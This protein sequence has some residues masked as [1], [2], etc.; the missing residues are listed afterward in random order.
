MGTEGLATVLRIGRLTGAGF[1]PMLGQGGPVARARSV[2]ELGASCRLRPGIPLG[3]NVTS[4]RNAP[5]LFGLGP[6]DLVSDETILAQTLLQADGVQGR[7]NI[8]LDKDRVP[9]VGRFGW[10][11]ATASLESFVAEA[12]LNE[13]GVTS[14]LAPTDLQPGPANGADRCVGEAATLEDDGTLVAAVTAFVASLPAPR[15]TSSRPL[16]QQVFERSG[17]AA[18]HRSTLESSGGE[19]HLYSDLLLHDM[20]PALDDAVVQGDATGRDWRTT[21]LWGLG[22]RHRF[23]HDGRAT[24]LPAAIFAHGGEASRSVERFRDLTSDERSDL[25]SFLASL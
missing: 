7:P 5:A 2:A 23:L 25:M 12:F 18:C 15:P 4:V 21:P 9:R 8:V 6:I 1:D 14:Q 10:K 11:A 19:I 22:S 24:T 17:C 16:G 13:H 20:G 3:A